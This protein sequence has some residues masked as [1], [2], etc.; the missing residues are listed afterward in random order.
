M[1]NYEKL[2][3]ELYDNGYSCSQAILLAFCEELGLEKETAARLSS[4]FGSGMGKLKDV[5]GALTGAFM[6]IGLKYGFL[7]PVTKQAKD[8][9]YKRVY[10]FAKEFEK[11]FGSIYCRELRDW[12]G[13]TPHQCAS[14]VQ[15]T[16]KM[17]KELIM[18]PYEQQC[19]A[20]DDWFDRH[21]EKY[22][23]E[24]AAI[25]E[26]VPFGAGGIEIGVGTG[27]FASPLGITVGVEPSAG[28]AELA[29]QRGI[30]IIAGKA[31]NLPLANESY[32]FALSVTSICFFSNPKL[33]LQEIHRII[34]PKGHLV[35]AFVDK[36]SKLGKQY[37]ER[38]AAGHNF[39]KVASFYSTE[40]IKKMLSVVGFSRFEI[41]QT[42]FNS[43]EIVEQ[44]KDGYGEGSFV[45]IKAYK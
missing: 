10:D 12:S 33:A 25:A 7:P 36:D 20:Y 41:K 19:N 42:L 38:K 23:S 13:D 31:E 21:P 27:R 30:N 24:L 28:M 26:F 2:A 17:L 43:A 40:E 1:K 35:I 16:A 3:R 14:I 4:S 8:A 11:T 15:D 9:H 32:D 18:N 45:V 5:C 22:A 6:V 44:P 37:Q 39:Y 34:K 29:K